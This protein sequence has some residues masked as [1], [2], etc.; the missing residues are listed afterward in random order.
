M[1]KRVLAILTMFMLCLALM[2][3]AAFAGMEDKTLTVDANATEVEGQTYTTIQAAINYI[4][5]TYSDQIE[6][7]TNYTG[8]VSG[9]C[10]L[11]DSDNTRCN[12]Y[13]KEMSGWTITVKGGTYS[14][15]SVLEGLNS[16]TIQ[17][18]DGESV[19]IST[20]TG[21]ENKELTVGVLGKHNASARKYTVAIASRNIT[22]KGLNF[23]VGTYDISNIS[24]TYWAKAAI[25]DCL[26]D[27][28]GVDTTGLNIQNCSFTNLGEQ[29]CQSEYL[30]G[31]VVNNMGLLVGNDS[32]TVKGSSF[33]GFGYAI[34]IMADSRIVSDNDVTISGNTFTSCDYALNCYYGGNSEN[35]GTPKGQSTGTVYF[36]NNSVTGTSK[37]RTKVCVMD[38]YVA[39]SI[40]SIVVSGNSFSYTMVVI[41][42]IAESE[43]TV[44]NVLEENTWS[45]GSFYVDL[46]EYYWDGSYQ[47]TL[48]IAPPFT[49]YESPENDTGY[50]VLN[51]DLDKYDSNTEYVQSLIDEANATGSHTLSITFDE[52]GDLVATITALK[53]CI[54]WVSGNMPTKKTDQPGL[55]KVIVTDDGETDQ[56]DVAAGDPVNYKLTSN[57]PSNLDK[58]I[59]YSAAEG[60]T[61]ENVIPLGTVKTN[62]TT[63]SDGNE[64]TENVTYILTFHDVLNSSLVYNGGVKVS[65]VTYALDEDGNVTTA[66]KNTV[67]V[68]EYATETTDTSDGCSFE[69]SIDLL[70]LY[71]KG[72]ITEEDFGSAQIIVTYTATLD[73]SAAAG[74]YINEAWVTYNNTNSEHDTVTV[75]TYA[76]KILKY[77]Q[78]KASNANASPANANAGLAGAEFTLYSDSE[79][80]DE[81][82]NSLTSKDDGYITVDGLD[83]GTYYLV[84]TKAPNG[85]VASSQPMTVTVDSVTAGE[86]HT[87]LVEF[88]NAPIPSTGGAGTRMYLIGGACLIAAAGTVFVVSRKKKDE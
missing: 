69:V 66:V 37:L 82:A 2:P 60:S 56:D 21:S 45:N 87:I 85:Y 64:T 70:E 81:V 49:Y 65:L 22:F 12:I 51:V 68:S 36:T 67:N 32:M 39:G 61:N 30:T 73:S 5:S 25:T 47:G 19:T 78:E 29:G 50:W 48:T 77:D 38:Q 17:A 54:Y 42:N 10:Y 13:P 3:A 4:Y 8:E 72:L 74:S 6:S 15:F 84:E 23:T 43:C 14:Q 7:V 59:D 62:T 16:L 75:N 11:Q 44:N 1:K 86:D 46:D 55:D 88:A 28:G 9:L 76:I 27:M 18:A 52:N 58:Y 35:N 57:V 71:S 41:E 63:D 33:D 53:D 31:E 26:A 40:G 80:T 34:A 24:S 79:L 20:W 83:A